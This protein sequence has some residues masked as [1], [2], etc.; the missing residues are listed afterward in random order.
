MEDVNHILRERL[1]HMVERKTRL[2]ID[3][4]SKWQLELE[5]LDDQ[6]KQHKKALK[7]LSNEIGKSEKYQLGK[8]AIEIMME[9]LP[10]EK[11]EADE[12]CEALQNIICE[13]SGYDFK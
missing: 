5:R 6:I 11:H 8:D 2:S 4:K 1:K 9:L 10:V 7:I 13:L 12:G 3:G